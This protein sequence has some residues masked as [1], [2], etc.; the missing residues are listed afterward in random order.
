MAQSIRD[1][2]ARAPQTVSKDASLIEAARLMRDADV[3][4]VLV[5]DRSSNLVGIVTDRDIVIRA[6]AEGRDAAATPVMEVASEDLVVAS[7]RDTLD[8]AERLLRDN[9]LRRL[10]V[11]EN[12]KVIGV[13]S[14]GD[15]AIERDADSA[16]ADVS[17]AP[18]NQ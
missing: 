11:V 17:A 16:L 5:V 4:D 6:V 14:I 8:D 18:G 13:V 7:P 12:G 3:G 1:I 10:P 15:L 2:M 9:A